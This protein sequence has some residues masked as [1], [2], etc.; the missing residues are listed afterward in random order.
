M[1]ILLASCG[2]SGDD[3][4]INGSSSVVE[5]TDYCD[6]LISAARVLDDG[7]SV[8]R[9][10]ELLRR[11]EAAS[12]PDHA[13]TWRLMFELSDEPFSYEN[14][15][16]AIDSLDTISDDLDGTCSQLDRVFVDDAG[17]LRMQLPG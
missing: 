14:F 17:R 4:S 12:P 10:N 2:A 1:A 13:D 5:V 8:N 16:V 11:V 9:Y 6:E 3:G 7:G 15:N